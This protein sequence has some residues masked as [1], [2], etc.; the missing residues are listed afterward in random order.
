MTT[1][2]F[3][4][5]S[6]D[7]TQILD[8]SEDYDVIVEVG[9]EQLY[10][11]HSIIL[12]NRSPYFQKNLPILA[13]DEFRIRKIKK[14]HIPVKVFDIIIR[15]IYGGTISLENLDPS[16]IYDLMVAGD[17]FCL[18]EFIN[19]LE[20]YLLDINIEWLYKNFDLI[21]HT[22]F[23][24]ETFQKLQKFC[25]DTVAKNPEII[26]NTK[27]FTS[28]DE[29][30]LVELI[31]RDDLRLEEGKIWD[32]M[33]KWGIG[34]NPELH[35]DPV[36]WKEEDYLS[37]E[38]TLQNCLPL[39]RYFQVSG[40]DFFDKIRPYKKLLSPSL[41]D[42]LIKHFIVPDRPI[43]NNL[44]LPRFS[45][46]ITET[47]VALISSW[48]D[49]KKKKNNDDNDNN[50]DD[51]FYNV[52]NNPYE[53]SLIFRA[54][55]DGFST[56]AFYDQCNGKDNTI[57]V[58]KVKDTKEI[59]GGYNPLA[60]HKIGGYQNTNDSFIFSLNDEDPQKSK[61]S[62]IQ[63]SNSTSAMYYDGT[64]PQ[65]GESD[66]MLKNNNEFG[67]KA[68]CKKRCY[69]FPIR[70]TTD[71][72]YVEDYE[73]FQI[74]CNVNKKT[75]GNESKNEK[76]NDIKMSNEKMNDVKMS[77]ENV[78]TNNENVKINNEN[79]KTKNVKTK[80]VKTKNVKTSGNESKNEKMNDIK[81]S[82]EKMNDVKMS[83]ENVK[84]NNENVKIN[85]ENVKTKNVKTKNVKTKNVKVVEKKNNNYYSEKYS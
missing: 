74:I 41:W 18:D 77:N 78:K 32:Q 57:I 19:Y 22:C 81:M 12:R 61:L 26:F 23:K 68:F 37:L 54:S 70:E 47:Q 46:V 56:K 83:N 76:M 2:F 27:E 9:E 13:R 4:K 64:G 39:I 16:L 1:E 44:L 33:I 14:T 85:N 3:K 45:T 30:A 29:N 69:E 28:I 35:D 84:T 58:L 82:N 40:D 11:I 67:F 59:L 25:T 8:D 79:V 34:Q 20:S 48:I 75:S 52:S 66:L 55:R 62:R 60:W 80:N 65:F 31:K 50:D 21:Y 71:I 51:E 43:N 5:L 7:F 24:Y 63:S 72:S 17:E 6:S 15:Y 38:I 53:F 42:D 49:R 10:L 73:V 36:K